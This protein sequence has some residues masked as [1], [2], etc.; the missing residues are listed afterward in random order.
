MKKILR[1]LYRIYDIFSKVVYKY[2]IMPLIKSNFKE[3]GENVSIGRG[4]KFTFKNISIG[5][6]TSIGQEANFMSS[7]ASIRIGDNVMFGPH[8]FMITGN[9]RIDI[10]GRNMNDIK[11]SEKLKINDEDIVVCNDVWIGA[12]S[13]ILKGVTIN[14]GSVVAAGS[15]VNRD[16]PAYSIVAGVPA[17]VIKMRFNDIELEEHKKLLY[18]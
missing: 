2:L 17:K 10:I 3:C 15:I 16:V 7:K 4:G 14:E 1:L 11:E 5:N 9:H 12:N 6:H 8:V 13:I 18:K